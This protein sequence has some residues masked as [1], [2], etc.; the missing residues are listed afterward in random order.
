MTE[1]QKFLRLPL[2]LLLLLVLGSR[3]CAQTPAQVSI[4]LTHPAGTA[5][6]ERQ[7]DVPLSASATSAGKHERIDIDPGTR[8]Q[9]MEG[10]GFTLTGTRPTPS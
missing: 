8:F 1:K 5:R 4:R 2:L 3:L 9:S 10:F 6:W 7:P